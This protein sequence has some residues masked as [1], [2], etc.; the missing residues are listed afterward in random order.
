MIKGMNATRRHEWLGRKSTARNRIFCGHTD[1]V[2]CTLQL[3]G[4]WS[5]LPDGEESGEPSTS[6]WLP[7]QN[8]RSGPAFPSSAV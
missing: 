5:F 4:K 6:L 3:S 1:L 8:G 7:S 2:P